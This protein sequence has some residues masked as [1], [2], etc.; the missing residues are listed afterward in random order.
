[1]LH[2]LAD[3]LQRVR[4]TSIP[5]PN[6]DQQAHAQ[7]AY[8]LLERL[9]APEGGIRVSRGP[10]NPLTTSQIKVACLTLLTAFIEGP[11]AEYVV[12]W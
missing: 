10:L 4:N 11:A 6:Q 7:D 1:M 9:D 3:W 12:A 5:H 8:D 2:V